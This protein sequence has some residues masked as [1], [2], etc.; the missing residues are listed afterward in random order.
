VI[1][2]GEVEGLEKWITVLMGRR[3]ARLCNGGKRR[4][5]GREWKRTPG[6]AEGRSTLECLVLE[7]ISLLLM[8]ELSGA[9]HVT[10][11]NQLD[12]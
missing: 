12:N 1:V 8:K 6:G 2:Q 10:G 7:K 4:R 5:K 11:V 3:D 9:Y